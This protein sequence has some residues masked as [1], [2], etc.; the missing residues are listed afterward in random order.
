[1]FANRR[2]L[3]EALVTDMPFIMKWLEDLG[4]TFDKNPEGNY[5]EVS[6]GGACRRR[7]HCARDYTGLEILRILRK[8]F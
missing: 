3:V 8:K 2:D 7:L 5:V 1:L 6:G 4:V